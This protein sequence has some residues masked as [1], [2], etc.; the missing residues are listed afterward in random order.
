MVSDFL[1]RAELFKNNNIK[2]VATIKTQQTKNQLK[3]G[4]KGN[5]NSFFL[6]STPSRPVGFWQFPVYFFAK[7][8]TPFNKNQKS[9]VIQIIC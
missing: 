6:R 8:A 3:K 9:A 7:Y 2:K 1:P 4:S 5:I